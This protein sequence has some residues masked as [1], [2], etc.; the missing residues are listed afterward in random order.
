M[1]TTKPIPLNLFSSKENYDFRFVFGPRVQAL[2]QEPFGPSALKKRVMRK[3]RG[4]K[5]A[6]VAYYI[7]LRD[8]AA[9]LDEVVG[10][11]NWSLDFPTVLDAGDRIVMVARMQIGDSYKEGESEELKVQMRWGDVTKKIKRQWKEGEVVITEESEEPILDP[12][13]PQGQKFLQKP[14]TPEAKEL[15]ALRAG[16]NAAKRAAVLFGLGAYLYRFK[17]VNTYEDLNERGFLKNEDVDW[18][19]L[20][21]WA[22]PQSGATMVLRELA[23]LLGIPFTALNELDKEQQKALQ[24]A[25]KQ[26]WGLESVKGFGQDDLLRLAGCIARCAD[27]LAVNPQSSLESLAGMGAKDPEPEKEEAPV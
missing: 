16:P 5:R 24:G 23:N 25:L 18:K 6:E 22:K 4:G 20:P 10:P 14:N 2:L 15:V 27:W 13:D 9:R 11:Q 21:D 19:A 17:E 26:Y 12:R 3:V 8:M 7:D 1:L